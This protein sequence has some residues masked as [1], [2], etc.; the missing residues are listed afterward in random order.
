MLKR[1]ITTAALVA[2]VAVLAMT[3]A[4]ARAEIWL[5]WN[6]SNVS[7]DGVV[8]GGGNTATATIQEHTNAAYPVFLDHT[9]LKVSKESE[10]GIL[11]AAFI[12]D[13]FS[14]LMIVDLVK[15][16]GAWEATSGTL[17]FTDVGSA[18]VV[19]ASFLGTDFELQEVSGGGV[20][21]EL[22]LEGILSPLGS[23]ESILVKTTDPWEFTGQ[24]GSDLTIYNDESYDNGDVIVAQFDVPGTIAEM[25]TL[26]DWLDESGTNMLEVGDATGSIVPVPAAVVLGVL[27][28]GL[29][30]LKMRRY[31]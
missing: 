29:V 12:D 9:R 7:F 8:D 19:E 10:A 26:I 18:N 3:V 15:T 28:L 31:A 2:F 13:A 1:T 27:G 14:F 24:S 30:G 5:D 6:V 11:D 23:N 20:S 4:P 17:S 25:N 16:A 21:R 22:R